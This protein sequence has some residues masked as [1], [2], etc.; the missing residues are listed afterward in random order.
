MKAEA[1]KTLCVPGMNNLETFGR[2]HFAEFTDVF[3]RDVAFADPVDNLT[4]EKADA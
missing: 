2:W 1:M 3:E 4:N